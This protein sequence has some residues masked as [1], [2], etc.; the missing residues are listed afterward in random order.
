VQVV[1]SAFNDGIGEKM[2]N[3][4]IAQFKPAFPLGWNTRVAVWSFVQYSILS[5]RPLYVPHMV[6][7]DRGGVIRAE[8]K[9]EEA[10]FHAPGPNVRKELDKMLGGAAAAPAKTEAKK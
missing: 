8:Y 6:F 10:F 4:F 2:L 9:G 1:G 3:E 7:I 5:Q